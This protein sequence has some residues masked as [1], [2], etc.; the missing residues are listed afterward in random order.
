MA[1]RIGGGYGR[2][3]QRRIRRNGSSR[4]APVLTSLPVALPSPVPVAPVVGRDGGEG[5]RCVD[6]GATGDAG[7]LCCW[8]NDDGDLEWTCRD[9]CPYCNPIRPVGQQ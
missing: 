9:C 2:L 3:F 7:T 4:P 6:C 5:L 1:V 8:E